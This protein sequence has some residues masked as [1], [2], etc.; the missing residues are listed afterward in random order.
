ME[1]NEYPLSQLI[2]FLLKKEVFSHI[3]LITAKLCF[4]WNVSHKIISERSLKLVKISVIVNIRE[5]LIDMTTLH[6]ITQ[7]MLPS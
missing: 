7:A 6:K 1:D 3:Q 2:C 5:N 4:S